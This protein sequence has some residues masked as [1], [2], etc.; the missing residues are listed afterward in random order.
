M[1]KNILLI[2]IQKR[3]QEE[4]KNFIHI[5]DEANLDDSFCIINIKDDN[6]VSMEKYPNIRF[7]ALALSALQFFSNLMKYVAIITFRG[8]LVIGLHDSY[9][10][11]KYKG[12]FVSS[13]SKGSKGQ[14]LLPDFYAMRNYEKK[15][16]IIDTLKFEEKINKAVFV[17]SDTG[18]LD[19]RLNRRL[20][21][22]EWALEHKQECMCVIAFTGS[23]IESETDTKI[24]TFYPNFDSFKIDHKMSIEEQREYKFCICMDGNTCAWDRF[25]WQLNSNSVT[26]KEKSDN[27]C[28]YYPLMQPGK[29]YLE[30]ENFEDIIDLMQNKEINFGEIIENGKQFVNNYLTYKYHLLY[31][32]FLLNELRSL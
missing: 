12:I 32:A 9:K 26:L 25:V 11:D 18:N 2:N 14:V 28:W 1:N 15:L 8:K 17:G 5:E 20:Q 19:P 27:I 22:C 24:T 29:E 21:L 30:F 6:T 23:Q 7:L 10:E 13:R 31:T 4:S 16:D 3:A